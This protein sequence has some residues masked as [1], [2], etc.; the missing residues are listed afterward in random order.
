MKL[1]VISDIH[2]NLPALEAVLEDLEQWQP[3][4]VII[5]GDLINRGTYSRACLR[6]IGSRQPRAHFLKGN[7]ETFVLA[8]AD[9]PRE[10]GNPHFELR[11]FAH[12]T[13]DQLG[14]ALSE[15][16]V[17]P[18]QLDLTDR[19]GGSVHVTHGTRLGNRD[20]IRPETE[21][22]ELTDKLGDARDL[23]ITSHTH[24]PLIRR[25]DGMLVVNTGSVGSPFDRDPR[26]AYGRF[27]FF[28]GRWVAEI[29]RVE[30]DRERAERDFEESGF[31]Q[32]GGPLAWVMLRELQLSRGLMGP[33]M[34][35]YHDAVKAGQITVE[36][37]VKEFLRECH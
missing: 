18:D 21:A 29:V 30:Y 33:W 15:V 16:R 37:A 31:L 10:P 22:R 36:T 8:C 20:G 24:R 2:G 14:A 26:A 27:H 35:R 23:F 7:H 6:R 11:R 1:A 19:D 28:S 32:L 25:H 17:W 12:W 13:V 5:N 9:H 4:E 3:D 34:H